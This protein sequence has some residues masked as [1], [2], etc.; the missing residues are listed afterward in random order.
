MYCEEAGS[1]MDAYLA[2][3]L[4]EG[5]RAEFEAHLAGCSE[6]AARLR[7]AEGLLEETGSALKWA[8]PAAGF[9][10][11]VR[12]SVVAATASARPLQTWSEVLQEQFDR[13]PWWVISASVHA[14]ILLLMTIIT[15]TSGPKP[16]EAVVIVTEWKQEKP[17]E[18]APTDPP[19]IW[20]RREVPSDEPVVDN[21]IFSHDDAPIEEKMVT[22]N[23]MDKD[24]SRGQ[25]DAISDIPLGSVGTVGSIGV[26]P[27]GGGC[28]GSRSGGGRR[29]AVRTGG[30]S[31]GSES[32]VNLALEWLARHQEPAGNWDT[33][34]YGADKSADTGITGLA[35]LAFLGAGHTEIAGKYKSN[36][37]AS[38][39][40]L[41]GVQ[42]K[43]GQGCVWRGRAGD[44]GGYGAGY[45]HAIGSLA[46]AEAYGM[47]RNP[48]V[49]RA[50][51]DAVEYSI[52]RHQKEYSGWRY[53]PK[54]EP[55]TSVTGWFIMQLKSARVA[56]L[57]VDG[58]GF[59][60][61]QAWLDKVEDK[62]E[63][64]GYPGGRFSYQPGRKPGRTMT[65]AG[66]LGRLFMGTKPDMLRGGGE[67]L[68]E[69]LPGWNRKDFYY[70]Y[71]GTLVMFQM[72]GDYWK[73]WN[74]AMREMLVKNQRLDGDER[75]SWDQSD[76]S[77]SDY[78]CRVMSTALG[79]L[80]L[81]VYYR[82]RPMYRR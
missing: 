65:A 76:T 11:R 63:Y 5:S 12:E 17:P 29:R 67:V 34:K 45:H 3:A 9:E 43:Q 61:A 40:W 47:A 37:R 33:V 13:A 25:E 7:E 10:G 4:K 53:G 74:P 8:V 54:T 32:A 41:I 62:A 51:Q 20:K 75:G 79:A 38:T 81:E 30:G 80:C 70:W 27:G 48:I 28:F 16:V 58:K 2:D 14:V 78:K 72:G 39:R 69:N 24:S 71:Y 77:S 22:D 64:K 66:M 36:V 52:E 46:L 82:C 18:L 26:G 73:T 68:L 55:D 23:D 15:V 31:P 56:E 59:I 21:P 44:P 49:G 35:V 6:C 57:K 60:G 19:D 1:M 50:A 42:K